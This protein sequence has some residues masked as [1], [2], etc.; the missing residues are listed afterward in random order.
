M[1]PRVKRIR[2]QDGDD[3][4]D[5]EVEEVERMADLEESIRGALMSTL[6][7]LK[8]KIELFSKLKDGR[9]KG[10][11]EKL[12]NLL[13]EKKN[14]LKQL[15]GKTK[16]QQSELS[17]KVQ[18]FRRLFE[19]A[20]DQV[21]N[22]ENEIRLLTALNSKAQK[23]L[24]KAMKTETDGKSEI[25]AMKE[26]VGKLEDE[27]AE[28]D[29][30]LKEIEGKYDRLDTEIKKLFLLSKSKECKKENELE[31]LKVK[32]SNIQED[33]NRTKRLQLCQ[34][35]DK[36]IQLKEASE[37]NEKLKLEK[38]LLKKNVEVTN[39][40]ITKNLEKIRQLEAKNNDLENENS[41]GKKLSNAIPT[42]TN[43]KEEK[44][45]LNLKEEYMESTNDERQCDNKVKVESLDIEKRKLKFE[46][47]EGDKT[48][49][50]KNFKEMEHLK[51]T[52]MEDLKE[53]ELRDLKET[54]MEDLKETE[55]KDLKEAH[56]NE[57]LNWQKNVDHLV[58]KL[59]DERKS[60]KGDMKH[61]LGFSCPHIG[62]NGPPVGF[63]GPPIGF[64]GPP[65]AF[66]GPPSGFNGPPIGLN[67]PHIGFN[68]PPIGFN[69]PPIGFHGPRWF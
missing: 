18:V 10:K 19:S 66:N 46:I 60:H 62:F 48:R 36:K 21:N 6:P 2:L 65:I 64:N 50:M 14:D 33:L 28:K 67:G 13:A 35:L 8:N 31:M 43:L 37:Q 39:I 51:G 25:N 26:K 63:N 29:K 15:E 30:A 5:L 24:N 57:I 23:D 42:M 4:L 44:Q 1:E 59:R 56:E 40:T 3:D 17:K 49:E 11:V 16:A 61:L 41:L 32:N 45:Y 38:N 58:R 69:G 55:M 34:E 7:I 47:E 27:V 68:G 20:K 54:E 52:E 12:D 53:T 22:K 9:L